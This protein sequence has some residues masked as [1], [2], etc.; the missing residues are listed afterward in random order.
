MKAIAS[1]GETIYIETGNPVL[2]WEEVTLDDIADLA[3][4]LWT[5]P[6][7]QKYAPS[8]Q[9]RPVKGKW[10]GKKFRPDGIEYDEVRTEWTHRVSDERGQ[11]ISQRKKRRRDE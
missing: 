5:D 11:K 6:C 8:L 3:R 1:N 10:R 2:G 7:Y 4:D 9:K